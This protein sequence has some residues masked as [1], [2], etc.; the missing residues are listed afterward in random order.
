MEKEIKRLLRLVKST[1]LSEQDVT[2]AIIKLIVSD[3]MQSLF[4]KVAN[5]TNADKDRIVTA[6]HKGKLTFYELDFN[7]EKVKRYLTTISL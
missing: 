5:D 7:E 1:Q 3:V 2:D 4:D 6:Y